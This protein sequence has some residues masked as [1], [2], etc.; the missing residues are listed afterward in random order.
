[1]VRCGICG[2]IG[3]NKATCP[4]FGGGGII[5]KK[6]VS[7]KS[8]VS[9]GPAAAGTLVHG[10]ITA[11]G[12]VSQQ[13]D[14]YVINVVNNHYYPKPKPSPK[15]PKAAAPRKPKTPLSTPDKPKQWDGRLVNP[16]PKGWTPQ[17]FPP[18]FHM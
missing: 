11:N 6:P 3:H 16:A 4:S 9:K 12:S 18:S 7:N 17:M 5:K 2:G 15:P 13:N 10:G 8:K 14:N 1:M